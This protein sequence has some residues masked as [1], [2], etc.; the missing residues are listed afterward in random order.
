MALGSFKPSGPALWYLFNPRPHPWAFL[1]SLFPF[2]NFGMFFP[3]FPNLS[4]CSLLLWSP[5]RCCS[6]PQMG[7]TSSD[8]AEHLPTSFLQPYSGGPYGDLQ[9]PGCFPGAYRVLIWR[10]VCGHPCPWHLPSSWYLL[11]QTWLRFTWLH[12]CTPDPS[13]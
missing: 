11:E 10:C 1:L 7:G 8:H 2:L 13:S 12:S 6:P 3:I 5:W 9:V 4:V